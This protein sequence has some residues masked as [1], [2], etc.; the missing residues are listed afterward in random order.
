MDFLFKIKNIFKTMDRYDADGDFI[1]YTEDDPNPDYL[2]YQD[3]MYDD[4]LN[5]DDYKLYLIKYG[6]VDPYE[7]FD[8]PIETCDEDD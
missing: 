7:Y 6:L 1:M 5:D 8:G 4:D 3:H 2:I